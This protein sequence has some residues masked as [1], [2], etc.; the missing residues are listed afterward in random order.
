LCLGNCVNTTSATTI[1][2]GSNITV[3]PASM[4]GIFVG[5]KLNF[6]NGTGSP[7][8]V[9]VKQAP[10]GGTTFTADF[11][12]NHS[13]AYTILSVSGTWLGHLVVNQTG[14]GITITLYNGHPSVLPLPSKSGIIAVINAGENTPL[15]YNGVCDYGLFYTVAGT[16]PGDYTLMY[17]DMA[18]S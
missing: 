15:L 6:A 2:A 7:E 11:V 3:T 14:T 18:V 10:S 17:L 1:T 8:T 4:S 13:G 5:Q 9:V 16:T 12:N